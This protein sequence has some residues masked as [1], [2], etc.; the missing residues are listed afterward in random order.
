MAKEVIGIEVAGFAAFQ[1]DIK[2]ANA[3]WLHLFRG[4]LK[5]ATDIV[6]N[7]AQAR[8]GSS[9][10]RIA[11]TIRPS[12][13]NRGISVRAGGARAPHA[14]AFENMGKEG[15]FRHPVYGHRDRWVSQTAHPFLLPALAQNLD[16][17]AETLAQAVDDWAR[18]A[19]F[20]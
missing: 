17:L 8:I 12:V 19:G 10:S 9:S 16:K 14:P 13:T 5:D 20:K 3:D 6:V 1:R 4:K 18:E 15:Q 11:G 2:K 7:D